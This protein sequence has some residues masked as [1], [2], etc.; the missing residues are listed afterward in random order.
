MF[1]FSPSQ[2][3]QLPSMPLDVARLKSSTSEQLGDI[4]LTSFE[5]W[6]R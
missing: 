3:P 6:G 2:Q 4:S 5:E 1:M